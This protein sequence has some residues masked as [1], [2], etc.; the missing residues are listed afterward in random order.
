MSLNDLHKTGCVYCVCISEQLSGLLPA[1]DRLCLVLGLIFRLILVA[2]SGLCACHRV[3]VHFWLQ[4]VICCVSY[5]PLLLPPAINLSNKAR[6]CPP[7][8]VVA[9]NNRCSTTDQLPRSWS[10][11]IQMDSTCT[12]KH[13]FKSTP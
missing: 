10:I 6:K 2:L 12:G 9:E 11:K 5:P 8:N 1:D 7:K 13:H 4:G 3:L